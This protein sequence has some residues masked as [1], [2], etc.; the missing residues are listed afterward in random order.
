MQKK[1]FVL[2]TGASTGIGK[3][4]ALSLVQ[5][6][7]DVFAGVRKGSDGTLLEEECHNAPGTIRPIQLDVTDERAIAS[8]IS[9]I[10]EIVGD[11]GLCGLVNNAGICVVGPVEFVTMEQW[12][13]QFDVNLF[14]AIA[15]TQ[16]TLPLLRK[17]VTKNAMGSARLINISSIAGKV[18]QPIL[19]PYTASKHAMESLTDSLRM[20]VKPLGIQVCSV[21]PGAIDTPIWGKANLDAEPT[22]ADD[23]ARMFYGNLI[24][25]VT[26]AAKKAQTDAIPASKVADAVVACMLKRKPKTRYFIGRDA[27]G[28][29]LFKRILSDRM[30]DAV[31]GSFLKRKNEKS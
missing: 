4:C 28:A 12:R 1:K 22:G 27:K 8:A 26:L 21:N 23:P 24:D 17:Y 30:F 20:E 18:A 25:G 19:G 3:A 7:F 5:L 11:D 6:G 14:G 15:V 2:V 31:L 16:A 13:R 29:A 10:A 9:Q